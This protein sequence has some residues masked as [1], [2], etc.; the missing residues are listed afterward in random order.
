MGGQRGADDG[1]EAKGSVGGGGPALEVRANNET[2]KEAT[3]DGGGLSGSRWREKTVG[4]G[5]RRHCL[6]E[7]KWE[8]GGGGGS[9]VQ[10]IPFERAA[11]TIG[12]TEERKEKKKGFGY[13][14]QI[15]NTIQWYRICK[16]RVSVKLMPYR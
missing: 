6:G 16:I 15:S 5:T 1:A 10:L 7:E 8:G 11:A 9:P 2:S 3:A 4:R 14:A 13:V 12:W